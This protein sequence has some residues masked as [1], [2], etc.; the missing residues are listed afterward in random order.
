MTTFRPVGSAGPVLALPNRDGLLYRVDTEARSLERLGTMRT[1]HN[2]H[3]R[4]LPDGQVTDPVEQNDP[5]HGR[6]PVPQR[7]HDSVEP[8]LGLLGV[9]LVGDSG[10]TGPPLG[11]VAD[12]AL[13]RHDRTRP[14][15]RDPR[16]R[17]VGGEGRVEESHPVAV[18]RCRVHGLI[19]GIG[20]ARG[21]RAGLSCHGTPGGGEASWQVRVVTLATMPGGDE[22]SEPNGGPPDPL[23][24]VWSHPSELRGD[25]EPAPAR[26]SRRL[27]LVP[28]AAAVAGSL[29]TVAALAAL[30]LLGD[31]SSATPDAA[32]EPGSAPTGALADDIASTVEPAVV[33]VRATTGDLATTSSG[34]VV[35]RTGDGD[36]D[37]S[38]DVVTSYVALHDADTIV[39][40]PAGR[41]SRTATLVGADPTT[42]VAL[43]RMSGPPLPSLL[44]DR[45]ITAD[46]GAEVA[47]VGAPEAGAGSPVAATVA[48]SD[49]VVTAGATTHPGM[50]ELDTRSPTDA[51][52]GVVVDSDGRVVGVVAGNREGFPADGATPTRVVADAVDQLREF[53]VVV[54]GWIGLSAHDD[55]SGGVEIDEVVDGGPAAIAGLAPGDRITHIGD[56]ELEGIDEL[57]AEVA[58]HPPGTE[59]TLTVS[60]P[61]DREK[62]GGTRSVTA[63]TAHRP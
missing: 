43:L 53:G 10:H 38:N 48:A 50:L 44:L 19:V 17:L 24:R 6:P 40:V 51:V 41:A 25:P 27:W 4:S 39:V 42:D 45:G 52:G 7:R 59:L 11:V 36:G 28:A 62:H 26:P 54:P 37:L 55:V 2:H 20:D 31:S 3:D 46:A 8:H 15:Q 32:T 14:G 61:G 58:Q 18:P 47:V 34:V 56:D 9:G 57:A 21:R 23:D 63:F 35:R 5:I 22:G 1:G 13:E 33:A 29:V 49:M 12:H 30:G 60:N 16:G